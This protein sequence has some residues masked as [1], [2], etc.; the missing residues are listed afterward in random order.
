MKKIYLLFIV[1][2]SIASGW[3]QN[4]T[5]TVG[6]GTST[7]V[8]PLGNYYGYERSA[9]LYTSGEILY[10]GNILSLAWQAATGSMG[11]RPIKIYLKET[12]DQVLTS[13]TWATMITGATLVYDNT[14]DPASGWNTY[15]LTSTFN[16]TGTANLLVL[17]E[18]NYGSYG[19]SPTSAGNSVSYSSSAN[20]HMFIRAD[21]NPPTGTGTITNDR[22]NIQFTFPALPSCSTAISG[23]TVS[24]PTQAICSGTTPTP[25]SVPNPNPAT[26]NY[27]YQWEESDDNGVADPWS[28]VTGGSGATT[29]TY[30]PQTFTGTTDKYY[31]LKVTCP[32]SGQSAYSTVHKISLP[33]TPNSVTGVTFSN[34]AESGVSMSWTNGNG[35]RRVVLINTSNTFT[36]LNNGQAPAYVP[37]TVL[38]AGDLLLYDGTSSS[39]DIT[40]MDCNTTY[41]FKVYEYMRCGS[42]APYGYWHSVP[43]DGNV[44][45]GS[46]QTTPVNLAINND[47]TGFTGSNLATVFPG[48]VEKT[49]DGPLTGTSSAWTSSTIFTGK[50]TAKVN[51]Y[52]TDRKEWIVSPT[53]NVTTS[54]RI[55]LKAAITNYNSSGVDN[56]GGM[57]G[58][59]DKVQVMI[60]SDACGATWTPLYI[61]D[62]STTA[63]L[64]NVLADFTVHIPASYIG[65]TVRIGFK[66][67]DGPISD[68]NDYDFHIGDIVIEETP[69]PSVTVTKID[70]TCFGGS[71]GSASAVPVDGTPPFTYSWSPSGGTSFNATNLTAGSYTVTITD[72]NNLTASATVIVGEP[73][74]ILTN[75]S[76]TNISCKGAANGA[77]TVAPTGGT[78]PYTYLW[79]TGGITKTISSLTPGAYSLTIT[80]SNGCTKTEN[81]NIT[82]PDTLT[83]SNASQIDVS[84]YG[85]NDGSATVVVTGGTLP[86][87][88]S[89]SP[90]GGT[91]STAS[92][93]TAG[94]YTVTV[95]DKNGCTTTQSFTIIQPIPLMTDSVSQTN[96]S[97]KGGNNGTATIN[98][99]G[100]NPPY[101]YAWSPSG[102]TNATGTGLSAGTY[103]V[104]VTDSTGNTITESFTITEPNTLTITQ[105]TITNV[106]CHGLNTGSITVSIN[107][108]TAPYSYNWS[109]GS[110]N[111]MADN[112]VAGAYMLKVTDANGCTATQSFTITEPAML[113]ASQGAITHV[114][115]NG[116][117]N[118]SATVNVSGGTAPY[119]YIWSNGQTGTSIGNLSGGTYTVTVTDA[120]NCTVSLSFAINE[121]AFVHPPVTTNQN[122][123]AS[124]NAKISDLV[125]NGTNVKW[126]NSSTGGSALAANTLLVNGST[127]YATQTVNGCESPYRTPVSVTFVQTN[128]LTSTKLD[129]CGNSTIADVTIDGYNHNQLKWYDAATSATPLGANYIITTGTYYISTFTNNLCE[130]AKK[131]IQITVLPAVP[132]PSAS[133][134]TICNGGTI[135]D[136][137]VTQTPGTTLRWYTT[138][139]STMVLPS[140]TV[141]LSGTYYV[142]QVSGSCKSL[143]IPVLVQ[144]TNVPVPQI[145]NMTLCEGA[146]VGNL[147]LNSGTTQYV[148]YA[149]NSTTTALP[150]SHLITSGSYFLAQEISG[151]ISGR[152]QV[153][154]TVNNRP[155]SP[156]GQAAQNFNFKATVADLSM[157]QNDVAW[158]ETYDNALKGANQLSKATPL[159]DSTT[160][161]G[162]LISSNGCSSLPTA[163][164]VTI[165]LGIPELDLAHLRY[166]PNPVES[167]LKISYTEPIKAVEV[168]TL[169]GQKV[170]S[171]DFNTKDVSI[172]MSRFSAGTYVIKI[173]THNASQ[174]VKVIKK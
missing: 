134:Q 125:A 54:T 77:I 51:L 116:N 10:S 138:P 100:G 6:T 145:S 2:L 39:I 106:N 18:A 104:L 139:Q 38:S 172:D 21:G 144:I 140:N 43:T 122:F 161:Y 105:G 112:L 57:A 133:A 118:G 61:F 68:V 75:V 169:L 86:Y 146:T 63:N 135:A 142:E 148:W 67:T 103:T 62:A 20:R 92:G 44:T 53:F 12:S 69:P 34:I 143:R 1:L 126:Y 88:Y 90:S 150:D 47:F 11:T 15:T 28:N 35:N 166:Y 30:S 170:F 174:F 153:Y 151:C 17:V 114:S 42:S 121:P 9:S 40:G 16:Y 99:M 95:T 171:N 65:K 55:K 89:W 50:R 168:Y 147:Y 46:F 154:V 167:E 87:S 128:M 81:Y 23:G 157:S 29:L 98:A 60:S 164:T 33:V 124:Q 52:T 22:P 129:I 110:I 102:G 76:Q 70:N 78:A 136:L 149:N 71:T 79:S 19:L 3:S 113:T 159:E 49:G 5:I 131:P 141:L 7:Q 45:T 162:S 94:T 158:F 155:A 127:Y 64:T 117:A 119:T 27:T 173:A 41:Y 58:T 4:Q 165:N 25:I 66:A 56:D 107:G 59:D 101:T 132:A 14:T 123:C 91:S 13:S 160:Y 37:G 24:S 93:L 85:G 111:A 130:S 82:E 36:A 32:V 83:V 73:D 74:E 120:N 31:R 8:Y 96:V 72:S 163:V 97:C 26:T 108:G 80:D 115:C 137:V 48:W 156:T 84:S 109:N 152:T